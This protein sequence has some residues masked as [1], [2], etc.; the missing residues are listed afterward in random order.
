M[1]DVDGRQKFKI[2]RRSECDS[3]RDGLQY[4]SL[5]LYCTVKAKDYLVAQEFREQVFLCRV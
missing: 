3:V 1:P 5:V 4:R 2:P